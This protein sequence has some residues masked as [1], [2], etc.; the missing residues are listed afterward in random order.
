MAR[1]IIH[2][3][4]N[5]DQIYYTA[6]LKPFRIVKEGEDA[7]DT[8]VEESK[9]ISQPEIRDY[10]SIIDEQ[11]DEIRQAVN[12]ICGLISSVTE[13]ELPIPV[14]V[15]LRLAHRIMSIRCQD[16]SK[17]ISSSAK[18]YVLKKQSISL[19]SVGLTFYKWI[20]TIISTNILPFQSFMNNNLL[21][22]LAWTR[23][24][25]LCDYNKEQYYTIRSQTVSIIT[26][27]IETLSL[28]LN[29]DPKQLTS[30]VED[31]LISGLDLSITE[32]ACEVI[33]CLD[34]LFIAYANI[35]GAKL[36]YQIKNFVIQ[37][38][39]K[40]YRDFD[41]EIIGLVSRR[42]LLRLLENIA[43]SPF[44]TSTTELAWHVF[45]LCDRLESDPEIRYVARRSLKV[46]LAHRPTIISHF[47]V[48]DCYASKCAVNIESD[49]LGDS[50]DAHQ[51]NG[52]SESCQI[53]G[54]IEPHQIDGSGES[55]QM[56]DSNE[57]HRINGSSESCQIGGAIEP[58]QIDG[59]I[60]SQKIADSIESGQAIEDA[61]EVSG[62]QGY[63]DL[64]VE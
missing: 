57:S 36:E 44:A 55:H 52:S 3:E 7:K 20:S 35:M 14:L 26:K 34:R 12:N 32:Y 31:E 8:V 45:E 64:F 59:S 4:D 10:G 48:H 63:L 23:S 42:Q 39:I 2:L 37:T 13:F 11:V 53:G 1:E 29:L 54:A 16:F 38:C 62:G 58:H 33:Q 51:I 22:L 50:I 40:I 17:K 19:I 25:N 6:G 47:D 43:N 18:E 5:L 9:G 24:S 46:G 30:L 56:G 60:E 15:L 28:N 49:Q 61:D 41:K 21:G 27:M